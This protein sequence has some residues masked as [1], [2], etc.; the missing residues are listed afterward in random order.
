MNQSIL[1]FTLMNEIENFVCAVSISI[2]FEHLFPKLTQC[3][4]II[5]S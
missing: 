2:H 1:S 3:F 5:S 4:T